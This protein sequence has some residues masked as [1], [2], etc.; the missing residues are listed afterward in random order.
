MDGNYNSTIAIDE[1]AQTRGVDDL[2]EDEIVPISVELEEYDN[3]LNDVHRPEES[4]AVQ[5][6]PHVDDHGSGHDGELSE[7]WGDWE[8]QDWKRSQDRDQKGESDEHV[9]EQTVE[10]D[11]ND[12]RYQPAEES[13][14]EPVRDVSGTPSR[15]S[16]PPNKAEGPRVQA[17]RG[18]RSG[19]GGI[20]KV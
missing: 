9:A 7:G 19:T 12:Y 17:V 15:P 14:G 6:W 18:D 4:G 2:F 13:E 3:S 20:K 10:A 5:G 16:D 1:F 8:G 11:N